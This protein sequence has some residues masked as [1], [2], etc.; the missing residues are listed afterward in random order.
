MTFADKLLTQMSRKGFNQQ[1]LAKASRVSDSEV[2]RIL[3]GKSQPGLENAFRLARAVGVS[4][5]FLADETLDL[6]PLQTIA[7]ASQVERELLEVAQKLGHLKA[8]YVLEMVRTLGYE[9]ANRRLLMDAREKKPV[10]EV[11]DGNQMMAA[12]TSGA[13]AQST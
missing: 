5:D 10:I 7:P 3:A 8:L 12:A 13:R 6:D 9:E 4:L 1:K 2:S 11:G